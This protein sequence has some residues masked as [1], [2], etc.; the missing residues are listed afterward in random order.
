MKLIK[1][2]LA[3][4]LI[5][6]LFS[7]TKDTGINDSGNY[8][9][10]VGALILSKCATS[11][12]HNSKS[13]QAASNLNLETW[14]SL[15]LGSGSGSAVIPFSSQFSSLCYYIN[16]YPELGSQ[17]QPTMPL[18]N[19]K[20]SKSEVLLIKNWIDAGAPDINGNIKWASYPNQKKLY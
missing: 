6:H 7:C 4:Y 17:N 3:F 2:Y 12:C 8:P 11:G 14:E 16:T 13:Y 9:K 19:T 10:E 1:T 20:L 18:N 15:F 5:I